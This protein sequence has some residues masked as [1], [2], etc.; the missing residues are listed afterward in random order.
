M[1]TSGVNFPEPPVLISDIVLGTGHM[2]IYSNDFED[3]NIIISYNGKYDL[4]HGGSRA[5]G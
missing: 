2:L 3:A 1:S 4:Q 5:H